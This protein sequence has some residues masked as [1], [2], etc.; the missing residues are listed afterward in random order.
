[1]RLLAN[2]MSF[3]LLKDVDSSQGAGISRERMRTH[4]LEL[5]ARRGDVLDAEEVEH[6]VNFCFR[7]VSESKHDIRASSN[8]TFVSKAMEELFEGL[9]KLQYELHE[10]IGFRNRKANLPSTIDSK[11][12]D[13]D[14]WEIACSSAEP[15]SF[16]N[17]VKLF[18]KDRRKTVFESFFMPRRLKQCLKDTTV[19]EHP[20]SILESEQDQD[21]DSV[22]AS[23]ENN[24][25][26]LEDLQRLEQKVDIG[27]REL[28]MV[29][30]CLRSVDT[31]VEQR[32][33]ELHDKLHT[34]STRAPD[35]DAS[36]ST[37]SSFRASLNHG[38]VEPSNAHMAMR[39]D[40]P[41]AD[42]EHK[43]K[44]DK[45]KHEGN[46]QHVAFQWSFEEL[47]DKCLLLQERFK[48]S[49]AQAKASVAMLAAENTALTER[50]AI[51]EDALQEALLHSRPKGGQSTLQFQQKS[52][53][54]LPDL[55][56]GV[57]ASAL[58]TSSAHSAGDPCT[59]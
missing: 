49:E 13:V 7:A 5:L 16:E 59:I 51:L 43:I 56:Q 1:M 44:Q 26:N 53:D 40:S 29:K 37:S 6:M 35:N 38:H 18:D 41:D 31:S 36:Q 34:S 54:S 10:E 25:F 45:P 47:T 20:S 57:I 27:Q 30:R 50:V 23:E 58:R 48:V 9:G 17:F 33:L 12:V 15:M 21:L 19:Q 46:S 39:L 22:K 8:E 2:K 14:S 4:V 3:G 32:F 24:G 11:M 42:T 52:T 28:Q 55:N